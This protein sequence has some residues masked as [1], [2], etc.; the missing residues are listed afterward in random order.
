MGPSY[1][2]VNTVVGLKDC[3]R[4]FPDD[5]HIEPEPEDDN[6]EDDSKRKKQKKKKK[7][8]VQADADAVDQSQSGAG[9]LSAQDS[10]D[11]LDGKR[12]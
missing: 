3:L 6:G 9:E 1:F 7:K 12:F 4:L 8:R 10:E 2:S 5:Y 11:T